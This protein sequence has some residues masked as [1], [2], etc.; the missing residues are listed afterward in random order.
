MHFE[1]K[2]GVFKEIVSS[3]TSVVKHFFTGIIPMDLV[4]VAKQVN[5]VAFAQL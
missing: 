5:H 3:K 1:R 4:G 2:K